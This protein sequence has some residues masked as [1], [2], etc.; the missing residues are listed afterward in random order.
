M[1]TVTKQYMKKISFLLLL[2]A[3]ACAP[4]V[5]FYGFENL[6]H[7]S[8]NAIVNKDNK[9]QILNK[10]GIPNAVSVD[11][12]AWYYVSFKKEFLAFFPGKIK[13]DVMLKLIFNQ[14]GALIKKELI[15]HFLH[16][17]K[18]LKDTTP[19]ERSQKNDNYLAEILGNI[20]ASP[21]KER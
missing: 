7:E 2:M 13:E 11:R 6:T 4:N 1:N 3:S 19:I 18:M 12:N 21:D 14:K 20:A 16:K 5:E 10:F 17:Q 8:Q 15:E 9:T